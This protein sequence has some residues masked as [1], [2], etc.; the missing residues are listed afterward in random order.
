MVETENKRKYLPFGY[1][2]MLSYF[3]FIIIPVVFIGYSANSIFVKSIREQTRNNIQGTLQQMKD[4]ISYKIE[5]TIRISDMLYFDGTLSSHLLHYEEGWVSYD[6]TTN[7]L[8]PKFRT[9]IE[10]SSSRM[11]LSVY[12]HNETLPEIYNDYTDTDPLAMN[13]RS[14]DLYHIKRIVD[15]EWY[16]EYPVEQY[17]VTKVWKQVED[18][19]RFERISLL[20]RIVNRWILK[21]LGLFESVSEF[22]TYLKA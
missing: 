10:A 18:D 9:S 19:E 11:W 1:K 2:L 14:M 5:D 22:Q 3:V 8:L 15:K 16:L 4:N 20:R 21:K 17:G 13:D 7:Y 12:L 6:T